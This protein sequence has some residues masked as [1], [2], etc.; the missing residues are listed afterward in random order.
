MAHFAR[1]DQGVQRFQ[2]VF[3]GSQLIIRVVA[4]TQLTEKVGLPI[5]PVQLVEVNVVG[6]QA[7]QA[8]G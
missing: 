8:A 6:L 1:L 4:I 5:G 7:L 2:G 3:K